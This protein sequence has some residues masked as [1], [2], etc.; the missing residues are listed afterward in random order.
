[1]DEL[2]VAL[3][4]SSLAKLNVKSLVSALP[5]L[6]RNR[7]IEIDNVSFTFAPIFETQPFQNF[8]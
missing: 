6:L 2:L 1:M 8:P 7:Y 4:A 5:Y 3:D